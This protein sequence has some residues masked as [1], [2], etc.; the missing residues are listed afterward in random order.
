MF[1][2][3]QAVFLIIVFLVPGFVWRTVEAQFIYLDKRLE[4]E[5][6][7]LGLLTRSTFVYLPFAALLYRGWSQKWYDFHPIASGF[8]A[9]GLILV[10]PGLMGFISGIARQH[11]WTHSV[12][13][14]CKIDVFEQHRIPTAW[15]SLFA[16]LR[17]SWTI[18]TLKNGTKVYGYMSKDSFVSS[19]PDER[20]IYISHTLLKNPDD[21]LQVVPGTAG[22]YI[23]ADEISTIEFIKD[24]ETNP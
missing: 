9:I 3:F 8:A 21:S 14:K 19:D 6:F 16:N 23:R 15:D 1:E 4:W 2:T 17:T 10:L 7:A 18:V 13:S 24:K 12:M 11:G 20:D 5:K 22:V